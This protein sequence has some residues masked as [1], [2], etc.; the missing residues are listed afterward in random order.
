MGANYGI[1]NINLNQMKQ[2]TI[3]L[4]KSMTE[5]G[6]LVIVDPE[7]LKGEG[8][9]MVEV[10]NWNENNNGVEIS[11]AHDE[12][13]N[14]EIAKLAGFKKEEPKPEID[15]LKCDGRRFRAKIHGEECEGIIRVAPEDKNGVYL[16]QNDFGVSHPINNCGKYKLVWYMLLHNDYS[17]TTYFELLPEPRVIFTNCVGEVFTEEDALSG[18]DAW[19]ID[20]D[21]ITCRP[22]FGI[23]VF[24]RSAGD[25]WQIFRSKKSLLKYLY[26]TC[27]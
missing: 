8:A 3:N 23:T 5:Q 18:V 21:K 22:I 6:F 7:K 15:L 10:M 16:C 11:S 4:I 14:A 26:E 9:V 19:W 1:Y 13:I 27:E 17:T 25:S 2:E 12:K 24:S 20:D